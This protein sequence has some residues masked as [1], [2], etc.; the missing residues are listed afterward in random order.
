MKETTAAIQSFWATNLESAELH[1]HPCGIAHT[2]PLAA[3][4]FTL[5]ARFFVTLVRFVFSWADT[6]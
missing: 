1:L 6:F 4:P 5:S 3:V 2:P